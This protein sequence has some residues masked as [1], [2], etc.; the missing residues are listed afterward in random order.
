MTAMSK[1]ELQLD[2]WLPRTK[3]ASLLTA[4]VAL[5]VIGWVDL[6]AGWEIS[7]FV[8]YAIPILLWCGEPERA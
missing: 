5:A 1:I 4:A 7:L 6:H 8:I 2:R 3:G